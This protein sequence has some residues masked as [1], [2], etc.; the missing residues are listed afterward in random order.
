MSADHRWIWRGRVLRVVDG[1][2]LDVELDVGFH[3][4]RTERLRLANVNCPEMH[5][6]THD[7]GLAASDFTRT[8]VYDNDSHARAAILHDTYDL[9]VETFKSD[10]FGRYMAIVRN[11][12]G[13]SLN[14]ALVAAGHAVPYRVGEGQ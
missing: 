11:E 7:A 5:G 8:W 1:D 2:T 10:N 3:A 13:E 14:D 6:A 12:A 4:R 9:T